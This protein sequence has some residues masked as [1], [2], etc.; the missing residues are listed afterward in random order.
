MGDPSEGM[1]L[2]RIDNNA[3]YSKANCR[4]ENV[5]QQ[6][7][8]R[9]GNVLANIDG[10]VKTCAEWDEK[11]GLLSGTVAKRFRKGIRGM[12]LVTPVNKAFSR[13]QKQ[14]A[15]DSDCD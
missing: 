11:A 13:D 15:N 7:R 6:A 9:R 1:T 14:A 3:G 2:G 10:I 12:A 5:K 8:N 4:W